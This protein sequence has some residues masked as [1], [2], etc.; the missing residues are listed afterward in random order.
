MTELLAPGGSIEGMKAAVNAGA[1]AIYMGGKKFGARAFA[2]NPEEDMLLEGLDY[3]HLRGRKLYLTVNT[4][5]KEEELSGQLVDYLAPYYERGLD[6]VLVQD[7]GALAV[8]KK[9]FPDMELHASTQMSVQSVDG[10]KLLK[11]LGACRIVPARE[12]S[13]KEIRAIHDQ[14]DI[15]IEC[16]IHGALCYSYS[17]QC[18]M[19]SMIGGRSGNRGRCAQPCRLPYTMDNRT[20]HLLSLK[21]ASTLQVLPD[22]I[23][24][25]VFSFKIEG[26]M[27][28]AEYAAGVAS[29][30]RKYI[31]LYE[32]EGR[33]GYRVDPE[34]ERIL[35]DLYNRG[36]FTDGFY[37]R[38]NGK[39]MMCM[40]SPSHAGTEAARVLSVKGGQAEVKVLEDLGKGDLLQAGRADAANARQIRI[41]TTAKAGA[42]LRIPFNDRNVKA[43]VLLRRMKNETLLQKLSDEYLGDKAG[44]EV[45]GTCTLNEQG[46]SLIVTAPGTDGPVTA[47]GWIEAQPALKRSIT[48]ADL[49]KQLKKTGADAFRFG[50]LDIEAEDGYFLPVSAINGLRRTVLDQL[51]DAILESRRR[52]LPARNEKAD[53]V[54]RSSQPEQNNADRTPRLS[55]QCRTPQQAAAALKCEDIAEIIIDLNY[56]MDQL[57]AGGKGSDAGAAVRERFTDEIAELLGKAHEKDAQ[58]ILQLP[59]IWRMDA[60]ENFLK[61]MDDQSV[62]PDGF[63]IENQDQLQY[64]AAHYP[65][66]ILIASER[67][68]TWNK[69][70]AA[71]FR[72]KGMARETLPLELTFGELMKRGACGDD[73]IVYGH[74][75]LMTTASCVVKNTSGCRHEAGIHSITDRTG[76]EFTVMN[77]CGICTNIIYNSVPLNLMP[78]AD[79]VR[80]LK[81]GTVRVLLTTENGKEVLNVLSAC[82][83]VFILGNTAGA[84]DNGTRGH[85][86]KGVE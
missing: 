13:L 73:M 58:L 3:C 24:G 64:M 10:A 35:M 84:P 7:M 33:K 52:E 4:L 66:L 41:D 47:G 43:G 42:T 27:K 71:F 54:E 63:L 30:Y 31:D 72:S 23:D 26:R 38:H 67:L 48:A 76:A 74:L 21:D 32:Q 75:P 53:V 59:P 44:L 19:S 51:K 20:S 22:L 62:L 46:C 61:L 28:R 56:W 16:F 29:V 11:S 39:V 82:R 80:R 83:E 9:N 57:A 34:D 69:D 49:E 8:I 5:L 70:A 18:L 78:C 86:R 50:E 37:N 40:D 17:G 15:E 2:Q 1:D 12:L 81:P 79:D 36:G 85:F 68:Y 65:Q 55:A 45:S 14:V 77:H 6:G 60:K 25:G